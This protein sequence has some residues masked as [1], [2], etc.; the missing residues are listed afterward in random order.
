MQA[1]LWLV[2]SFALTAAAAFAQSAPPAGGDIPADFQPPTAGRDYVKREEMIPMRDGVKLYTVIVM[3]K[4]AKDA[5]IVLTRTP[6]NAQARA[7]RMESTRMLST[8]QLSDEPF[9]AA[10]YIRV[11]QDVRRQV[12]IRGRLRADAPGDRAAQSHQ[13]GSRHRRLRHDRVAGE[14]GESARVERPRR[15]D[16]LLVR[17][18]HRRQRAAR[19]APGARGR[20]ARKPDDRRLDGR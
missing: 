14:Q 11:Y 13:G 19:S 3:A 17:G 20:R 18:L 15:H 4:G 12:Q 2:L 8:L 6:Y 7:T 5:P 10:G 9:V 1:R 16:R